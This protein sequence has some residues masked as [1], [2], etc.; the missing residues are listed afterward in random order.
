MN[1]TAYMTKFSKFASNVIIFVFRDVTFEVTEVLYLFYSLV[2]NN[3]FGSNLMFSYKTNVLCLAADIIRWCFVA[4]L[5]WV[6]IATCSLSLFLYIIILSS[7]FRIEFIYAEG[8]SSILASF[9]S[10]HSLNRSSIFI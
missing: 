2:F 1:C 7:A 3:F 9:I 5:C 10:F 6:H 4:R 8:Y